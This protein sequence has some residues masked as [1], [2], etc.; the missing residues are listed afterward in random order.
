MYK[1]A[2]TIFDQ[3]LHISDMLL[4]KQSNSLIGLIICVVHFRHHR[5]YR[6]PF[7]KCS[8]T[9]K[10]DI[11]YFQTLCRPTIGK[12][13]IAPSCDVVDQHPKLTFIV[14]LKVAQVRIPLQPSLGLG[15]IVSLT[16][17]GVGKIRG[18]DGCFWMQFYWDFTSSDTP[19][20]P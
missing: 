9:Y 10:V 12:L 4:I 18:D 3:F 2:S 17:Q 15:P 8:Y 16:I 1:D 7:T 20:T 14:T 5:F 11:Y 19:L 6:L 13:S